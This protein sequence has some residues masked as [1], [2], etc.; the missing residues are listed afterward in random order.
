MRRE[1]H[2][3]KRSGFT[4]IE[5]LVVIAI[6]A[7]LIGMLLPAVQKVREA[8]NRAKCENNL[9]QI[10]LACHNYHDTNQAFP[11]EYAMWPGATVA[12]SS[13]A[14]LLP[15]L[16]QQGLYLA[17]YQQVTSGNPPTGTSGSATATPLSVLA[18]PSDS[19]IPSPA[20]VQD[21]GT[22]NYWGVT[23]YRNNDSGTQEAGNGSISSVLS[24]QITAITD[25]TSNTIMFGEFNNF[26]PNWPQYAVMFGSPANYPMS[27]FASV[28]AG[29]FT[30]GY[31]PFAVG[32]NPL[33]NPLS[34]DPLNRYWTF[35]SGHPG[36]ANF[37]F[38]DGSVH[39]ISNAINN[40]AT[41]PSAYDSGGGSIGQYGSGTVS[42]L[43]ALCT[44]DGGEVIDALQY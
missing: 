3:R 22:G 4:L 31:E 18:C 12:V 44:R 26:D 6:I 28:W 42:F 15:Y 7:I 16:E 39:F 34:N 2:D 10:G 8:A 38:C 30:I 35:G 43:G 40:A 14:L 11:M 1:H 25:G 29:A 37:V 24:V 19:G 27:L 9:K 32:V 23:S 36:G 13:F 5:L 41:V 17:L 21:P 33:N 20:V